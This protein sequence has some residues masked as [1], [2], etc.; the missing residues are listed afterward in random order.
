MSELTLLIL[1]IA[2]LAVLWA[3]VFAIV[4]ALRSDLFGSRVRKLQ[5]QQSP[6]FAA[7]APAP[8]AAPPAVQSLPTGPPIPVQGAA[9]PM[10]TTRTAARLVI[11]SGPKAG[12]EIPLGT[13]PLTIGRSGE[14]GLQIRDDYTSTHHAR[15]LLW[16]DEWVIQDLDSTNG[17]FLDGKRITVPTQVPVNTPVKVGATTFEL[18]R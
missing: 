4:Y 11:T 13:E 16:N 14:S 6:A 1:R 17:T 7:T 3:F 10:A 12:V 15:L 5:Q 2:F 18:R 8:P 9:K